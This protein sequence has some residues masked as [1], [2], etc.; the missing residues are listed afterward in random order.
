MCY[1]QGGGPQVRLLPSALPSAA[2]R[3]FL[4][5]QERTRL[6]PAAGRCWS[7]GAHP[8][9]LSLAGSW[10][11][12]SLLLLLQGVLIFHDGTELFPAY[13]VVALLTLLKETR[14]YYVAQTGLELLASSSL[15]TFA[16]QK[17]RS[18]AQAAVK[19]C[20]LRSLQPLPPRFK[21]SLCHPGWS[22]R[23]MIIAH[24]SLKLLGSESL[25]FAQAGVQ[26]HNLGSLQ[27]PP[28]GFKRFFCLSLLSSWDYRHA[29]PRVANFCI[30]SRDGVSPCC[31]GWSQTP[32]L[33]IHPR[34]PPRVLGLQVPR[35]S[36][37]TVPHDHKLCSRV[38]HIWRNRRGQ[39]IRS[40]MDKPRPGKTTF[41]I[42]SLALLP[43]ARLECSGVISAHCNLCPPGSSNSPASA[44][45]G[46]ALLPRLE[47]SAMILAYSNLHLWGSRSSVAQAGV[48]WNNHK[49]L[50]P[51]PSGLKHQFRILSATQPSGNFQTPKPLH[52][53]LLAFQ[54]FFF[55]RRSFALVAQAGV[56]WRRSQIHSNL[57]LPAFRLAGITG[58]RHRTWLIFV[59]LVETGFLVDQAGLKLP[60]SVSGFSS[61][62]FT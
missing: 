40:V 33:V 47:C 15:P 13:L 36:A 4:L 26:W 49:S 35:G 22:A 12:L 56:Q 52:R 34:W 45:Q 5:F 30:F 43:G 17:S 16:S 51:Q 3:A 50:Q 53:A 24:S 61:R 55:L 14:S 44:S 32:N 39:H 10:L 54:T 8:Q 2:P 38:S 20:N 28:P 27:T 62:G 59:F 31:L 58:A 1:G 11:R 37:N 7:C 21:V 18:V 57:R 19:S 29:P 25:S 42:M 6:T 23:G 46:F 41:V 60:I 9:G 48:Q